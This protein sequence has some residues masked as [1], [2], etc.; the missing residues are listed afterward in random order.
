VVI[1]RDEDAGRELGGDIWRLTVG[2]MHDS[3]GMCVLELHH[4]LATTAKIR[5]WLRIVRL[6]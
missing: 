5:K 2:T 1:R 3:L 6:P 4:A